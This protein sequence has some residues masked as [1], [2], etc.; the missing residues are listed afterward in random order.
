MA[1]PDID[2]ATILKERGFVFQ[3]TGESLEEIVSTPRT[4]YLGVDPTAD[5]LHVGNLL[6]FMAARHFLVRGH[7]VI[8][9][10]GSATAT[11]GDPSGKTEERTL[12]DEATVCANA[13]KIRAQAATALDTDEFVL[14]DNSEWLHDIRLLPFL[15]DIG[16]HFTVNEMLRKESVRRRIENPEGAISFTE[17]SYMLMQAYDFFMLHTKHGCDLQLGGSDQ[18][19]NIT[20]GIE[21]IRKKTGAA[22]HG[23]TTPLLLDRSTGRKFGK[24]EEGTIWLDATKTTPYAFY[25][26]WMNTDDER[27]PEY[28]RYYTLLPQTEL[29]ELLRQA[30]ATPEKRLG[31]K[32]LAYEVTKLFHGK[33]QAQRAERVSQALFTDTYQDLSD[34]ERA[35]LFLAAPTHKLE[36]AQLRSG[37]G[38][39]DVLVSTGLASSKR[40]AR[41]LLESGAV[42]INGEKCA[43]AN[44]MLGPDGFSAGVAA[45]RKGKRDIVLLY[46]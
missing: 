9:L 4:V 46:M 12:L 16:K 44:A 18:W 26:F 5:S 3:H 2:L 33:Q 7:T 10:V 6:P 1:Q 35:I 11:I 36:E 24:T 13:E 41:Q 20:A 17:F 21:L 28:L 39:V 38:V 40:E 43:D 15:R 34:D 14:V 19:G 30:A 22:V 27:V 23:I 8:V 25:Q 37:L 42:S 31:Q 45:I 29:N 32:R